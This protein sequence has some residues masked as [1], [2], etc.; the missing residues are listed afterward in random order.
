MS[1]SAGHLLINILYLLFASLY[2]WNK[3][4]HADSRRLLKIQ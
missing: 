3:G 2:R 1:T 4:W